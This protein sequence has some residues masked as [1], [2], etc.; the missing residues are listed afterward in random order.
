M[1]NIL[2][3]VSP[4]SDIER[5]ERA[6]QQLLR[7]VVVFTL[8]LVG[9]TWKLWTPQVE[10]P[11]V[12]FF[13]WVTT[14]GPWCDYLL[15]A[16][17]LAGLLIILVRAQPTKVRTM[18]TLLFLVGGCGLIVLNQHRFQ[19]W[20]YL[21]L[22]LSII[23]TF[24]PSRFA[25][26][27]SRLLII[28]LYFYSGV[29]KLD[30]SFLET[31]GLDIAQALAHLAGQSLDGLTTETKHLV[32]GLMP[33]G[34]L[35][36]AFLLW[37]KRWRA[38]GFVLSLVTHVLLILAL[39]PW[40]LNHNWGVLIWNVYFLCQNVILFGP[41]WRKPS[42]GEQGADIE[43]H[44]ETDINSTNDQLTLT[45][46]L[47]RLV[48]LAAVVLPMLE[49]LNLFDVWPSW[50]LYATRPAQ[51]KVFVSEQGMGKLPKSVTPFLGE[52][53]FVDNYRQLRID[54]WALEAVDAP[55]YPANRFRL[56]LIHS[57]VDQHQL[58]EDLKIEVSGVANRRTGQRAKFRFDGFL[59]DR[60]FG[61][62]YE[63]NTR[64]RQ[65]S[66]EPLP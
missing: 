17:M 3:Q 16:A 47:A 2:K 38:I 40:G 19:P 50:G 52:P 20:L 43:A 58:Q 39:S 30:L 34:E 60:D 32:V 48:L 6:A 25:V 63:F 37:R 54:R 59:S 41:R 36:T 46:T 33:V 28:S 49:W 62:R 26:A 14:V 66:V 65:L 42:T 44:L 18:G 61:K 15:M 10:F 23:I 29:S 9:V 12:P 45:A 11:Q 56:G 57:L 31:Q 21:A 5:A 27:G 51:M 7:V 8:V 4:P 55:V 1:F 24:L 22:L 64:P 35:I 53:R 13:S